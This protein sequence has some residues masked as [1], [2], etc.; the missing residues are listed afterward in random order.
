MKTG[1][2]ARFSVMVSALVMVS[3]VGHAQPADVPFLNTPC[4]GKVISIGALAGGGV[5]WKS[6]NIHGGRGPTFLVQNVQH[7]TNKQ[8]LE[9]RDAYCRP[10][11]TIGLFR[12]D[13]PYG[14]R[15]YMRTGGTGQS[16]T[17]LL[18]LA[19]RAGSTN[20]LVEGLNG[21]WI[22]VRDPRNRDGS[23]WK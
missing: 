4:A 12:T 15:Y 14:S 13:S 21:T 9:I 20:I 1:M 6:E 18:A 10:I 7:R 11:A 19:Q 8:T 22:R 23:V 17:E 5:L 2:L 3:S 16:D